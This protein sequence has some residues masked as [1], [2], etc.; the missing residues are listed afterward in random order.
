MSCTPLLYD[1]LWILP[2]CVHPRVVLLRIC[3]MSSRTRCMLVSSFFTGSR[4]V[5]ITFLTTHMWHCTPECARKDDFPGS[6]VRKCIHI[7]HRISISSWHRNGHIIPAFIIYHIHALH[8]H[9]SLHYHT[10][11]FSMLLFRLLHIFYFHCSHVI[12]THA[13]SLHFP[14][15]NKNKKG[16][17]VAYVRYHE[18]TMLGS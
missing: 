18:P 8:L 12:F 3:I 13:W 10:P 14:L 16:S 1:Y 7:M 11:S 9:K 2:Y 15:Q 5:H 17:I 4:K 6:C